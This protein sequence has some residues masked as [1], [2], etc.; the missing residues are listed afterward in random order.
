LLLAV[1]L[2]P[3]VSAVRRWSGITAKTSVCVGGVAEEVTLRPDRPVLLARTGV[4]VPVGA[5]DE[6]RT[7][8]SGRI[9]GVEVG[10]VL[11]AVHYLRARA[12]CFARAL[13]EHPPERSAIGV[14][15]CANAS[16]DS[17]Q[18]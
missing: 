18:T 6:C 2:Y 16:P 3:V 12:L 1:F 7:R 9:A 4:A 11:D 13:N 8:Y 5:C 10:P 14:Q 17:A 15:I